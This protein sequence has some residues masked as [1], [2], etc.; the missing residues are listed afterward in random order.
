MNTKPR[1]PK[2]MGEEDDSYLKPGMKDESETTHKIGVPKP[3][4]PFAGNLA[5]KIPAGK[6]K[7]NLG[8]KTLGGKQK[9]L[10]SAMKK[11]K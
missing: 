10:R 3:V 8:V 4:K 5:K 1:D 11:A 9:A 7:P 6:P 2:P